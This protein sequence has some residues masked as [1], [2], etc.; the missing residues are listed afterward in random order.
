[1]TTQRPVK[2]AMSMFVI[3]MTSMSMS[4]ATTI[5]ENNYASHSDHAMFCVNLASFNASFNICSLSAHRAS[6]VDECGLL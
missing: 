4:K 3:P 5:Q 1:M 6:T 2:H